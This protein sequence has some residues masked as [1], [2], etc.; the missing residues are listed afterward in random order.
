MTVK[1]P[2][3]SPN[4]QRVLECLK[5]HWLTTREPTIRSE[6]LEAALPDLTRFEVDIAAR[7]FARPRGE[8]SYDSVATYVIRGGGFDLPLTLTGQKLVQAIWG[9]IPK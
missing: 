8:L 3:Y 5:D 7:E 4:A 6:D 2:E 1:M 9:Q